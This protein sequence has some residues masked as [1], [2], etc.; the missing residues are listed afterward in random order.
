MSK[1]LSI[2]LRTGQGG[3]QGKTIGLQQRSWLTLAIERIF[4]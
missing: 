1:I 2:A 3:T 4:S